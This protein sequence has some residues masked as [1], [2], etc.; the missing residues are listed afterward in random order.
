[1]S[2]NRTKVVGNQVVTTPEVR[3]IRIDLTVGTGATV[4][5]GPALLRGV[6]VNSATGFAVN[7]L[8]GAAGSAVDSIPAAAPAGSWIPYGDVYYPDGI[9]TSHNAA[10]TA[11]ITAKYIPLG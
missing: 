1:M 7:F 2:S 4:Y 11:S 9:Y 6:N 3:G 10:E 8:N 5:A